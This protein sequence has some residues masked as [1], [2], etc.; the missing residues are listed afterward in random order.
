MAFFLLTVSLG[1]FLTSQVKF[2]LLNDDGSSKMSAAQ[3]FWFWTVLI[4][5]AALYL[6]WLFVPTNRL[7][8][9]MTPNE[10]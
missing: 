5:L 4:I 6:G 1:N 10:V 8:T 7:N 2:L 3:E 9:C